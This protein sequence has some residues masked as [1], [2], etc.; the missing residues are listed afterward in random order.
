LVVLV[1]VDV[2]IDVVE[3]FGSVTVAGVGVVVGVDNVI[4]ETAVS[5]ESV[6]AFLST[7][8]C[9]WYSSPAFLFP[10]PMKHRIS[11]TPN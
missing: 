4:F 6:L 10:T 1:K 5:P 8:D 11:L 3:V 2:I 7:C 9:I